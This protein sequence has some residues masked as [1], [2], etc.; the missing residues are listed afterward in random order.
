MSDYIPIADVVICATS[1]PHI[2]LSRE[3]LEKM[4]EGRE[5]RRKLLLIDISNPR[6]IDE[7]IKDLEN[8]EL[9]NIDGLRTI[10]DENLKMRIEEVGKVEEVIDRELIYLLDRYKMKDVEEIVRVLY[11]RIKLLKESEFKKA[12]TKMNGLS[13]E[14][15]KVILD[16]L[17][18]ISNKILAPTT[19]ALK[20]ASRDGNPELLRSAIEL[21]NLGEKDVS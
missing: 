18:S 7:N 13:E 12:I 21:F 6:N 14:Q 9:H 5:S 16:L 4:V 15:R 2:I 3:D 17:N 1:A 19:I 11:S 10:A 20:R 8:V